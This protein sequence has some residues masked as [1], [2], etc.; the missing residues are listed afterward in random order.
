MKEQHRPDLATA[1]LGALLKMDNASFKKEFANT[2]MLRSKRRG[3]LRNAA[4]ALGN[5]GTPRDLPVLK[6]ATGDGEP[7]V[8]EHADW[9]IQ[10]IEARAK[11]GATPHCSSE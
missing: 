5:V 10:Q 7:L 3:L 11:A 2:P 9:A 4:V 1:N 8:A 6:E